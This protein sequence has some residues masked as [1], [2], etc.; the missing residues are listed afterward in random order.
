MRQ[1]LYGLTPDQFAT[2]LADQG[3]RCAICRAD[4]PGGKGGWHVDHNH[5]TNAVRGLLCHDCNLGV[6][7]FGDDPDRLIAAAAYLRVTV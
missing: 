4:T 7:Q 3:G 2:M 6:G 1:Y 5:D